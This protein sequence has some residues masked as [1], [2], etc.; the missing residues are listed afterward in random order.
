MCCWGRKTRPISPTWL[1]FTQKYFCIVSVADKFGV[2]HWR[3]EKQRWKWTA[4]RAE[5][6]FSQIEIDGITDL[7]FLMRLRVIFGM[8][9]SICQNRLRICRWLYVVRVCVRKTIPIFSNLRL[10]YCHELNTLHRIRSLKQNKNKRKKCEN[11]AHSLWLWCR[12][13][14]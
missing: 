4:K 1:A 6:S 7:I 8:C 3:I 2:F 12:Y 14:M 10:V 11:R 13:P 9:S 5:T